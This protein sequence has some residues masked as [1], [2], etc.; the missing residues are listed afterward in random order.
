LLPAGLLN[1]F[2]LVN[3]EQK[4]EDLNLYLEEKNFAPEGYE[5][6]Q[7][8]SKGF[9]PEIAVQDFPIRNYKVMLF[10][11]RRRWMVVSSREIIK[12]DWDIVQKGTRITKDLGAFLKELP[13][14]RA[15]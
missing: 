15:G 12:R 5:N 10:I 6:V 9:M 1:F 4:G 14:Y 8:E 2:D 11:K 3:I 13:R 7:L